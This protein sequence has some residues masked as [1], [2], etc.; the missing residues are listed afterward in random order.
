MNACPHCQASL[1]GIEA[2]VCPSC[3]KVLSSDAVLSAVDDI[4]DQEA[5][6]GLPLV[7]GDDAAPSPPEGASD[8]PTPGRRV[9][10]LAPFGRRVWVPTAEHPEPPSPQDEFAVPDEVAPQEPAPAPP[11]PA[12]P[13]SSG[14]AQLQPAAE[15][16]P[17]PA[18]EPPPKPPAP[19]PQQAAPPVPARTQKK[20]KKV[21]RPFAQKTEPDLEVEKS[22]P[23]TSAEPSI[24]APPALDELAADAQPRQV[25]QPVVAKP[26]DNAPAQPPPQP[27]PVQ[28][29]PPTPAKT[30]TKS[31][32]VVRK[33]VPR[34]AAR[35]PR[36]RG[37]IA[38]L[39]VLLFASVATLYAVVTGRV[40]VTPVRELIASLTSGD[41]EVAG[42]TAA[43]TA[44][45]TTSA[46]DAA[47]TPTAEATRLSR[48]HRQRDDTPQP[49][50]VAQTPQPTAT[51]VARVDTPTP[52]PMR[53]ATPTPTAVAT[54]ARTPRTPRPT[55]TP[56]PARVTQKPT[57]TP[58]PVQRTPAPTPTP[59]P[60][61]DPFSEAHAYLK[62][63]E[64]ARASRAY[65]KILKETGNPEAQYWLSVTYSYQ[66]ED[67]MACKALKRYLQDAPNGRYAG[68]ARKAQVACN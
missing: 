27:A 32:P 8:A 39:V 25:T 10:L 64:L 14:V 4:D 45:G 6:A 37:R 65:K 68:R 28:S 40:D 5:F 17:A 48:N 23:S 61:S 44:T 53:V 57:P 12:P 19:A 35:P 54:V 15:T 31:K 16:K 29:A 62:A 38:L 55:A 22:A 67:G 11:K 3:G 56:T 52:T 1:E 30:P 34:K 2:G 63:G 13:V 58:T 50:P 59:K 21:V 66:G 46:T 42:Q 47:A 41:N 60:A 18:P 26:A 7:D 9:N 24:K 49:T 43:P 51:R 20:K 36:R 33:P